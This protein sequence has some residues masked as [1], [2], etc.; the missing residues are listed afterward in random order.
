MSTLTIAEKIQRARNNPLA[1]MS[2]VIDSIDA[3]GTSANHVVDA[4]NPFTQLLEVSALCLQ[5]S[6][7]E[8]RSVTRALYPNLSESKEEIYRHLNDRDKVGI[9]A[10]PS[11]TE[12]ILAISEEEILTRAVT[13]PGTSVRKLTIPPQTR[14]KVN[15][16]EFGIHYPIDIRVLSHGS[17]RAVWNNDAITS[18]IKLDENILETTSRRFNSDSGSVSFFMI[19]VPVEQFS[20]ETFSASISASGFKETYSYTDD[21]YFARVYLSEK[22]VWR[23]IPTTFSNTVYDVNT[24]TAVL[25]DTANGLAVSIPQVYI[26]SGLVGRNVRVDIYTTRGKMELSLADVAP[27][28]FQLEW[29]D[30]DDIEG[31]AYT[32]PLYA[33][34]SIVLRGTGSTIGGRSALTTDSLRERTVNSST[35]GSTAFDLTSEVNDLGYD[36]VRRHDNSTSRVYLLSRHLE[37]TSS[38]NFSTVGVLTDDLTFRFDQLAESGASINRHLNSLTILPDTLYQSTN[39]GLVIITPDELMNPNSYTQDEVI[40]KLNEL[41]PVYSPFHYVLENRNEYFNKRCYLMDQPTVS[42]RNFIDANGS[43]PYDISMRLVQIG[44]MGDG[45]R[46]AIQ[47]K[48]GDSIKALNDSQVNVQLAFIPA[49]SARRV[50]ITG[51]LSSA[52]VDDERVYTFDFGTEFDIDADDV[53]RVS[54]FKASQIDNNDYSLNLSNRFDVIFTVNGVDKVGDESDLDSLMALDMLPSDS[55][56]LS[57]ETVVLT[58][59]SRLAPLEGRTL[60]YYEEA[61]YEE[62]EEDV[63]MLRDRPAYRDDATGYI[64]VSV[65]DNALVYEKI[66]D[67]GDPVLDSEGNPRLLH[68]AGSLKLTDGKPTL[69]EDGYVARKAT[70]VTFNAMFKYA[71]EEAAVAAVQSKTAELLGYVQSDLVEIAK[72]LPPRTEIYFTPKSDMGVIDITEVSGQNYRVNAGLSFQVDLFLT[73]NAYNDIESHSLIKEQVR[74]VIIERIKDDIV[75]SLSIESAIKERLGSEVVTCSVNNITEEGL[76]VAAVSDSDRSFSIAPIMTMLSDGKVTPKDDINVNINS[77]AIDTKY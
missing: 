36:I 55:V 48:S 18:P 71:N 68:E 26:P 58:L 66:A 63:P 76:Q 50:Y 9:Y 49:D 52:Y 72:I 21:F 59:G 47:I 31:A 22:G 42:G 44:Y 39:E 56:V 32:S 54:G 19:H 70:F 6:V 57:H 51:E 11:R 75:S 69:I 40:A 14:F 46:V 53:I 37:T 23:E 45:Y 62:W 25:E 27:N 8:Q 35:G 20:L 1:L 30:F 64:D 7:D 5:A 13:I 12:I 77:V 65:E 29:R 4:S 67:I 60:T 34:T 17:I 74:D 2:D 41:R 38:S 3:D 16:I 15:G 73:A 61:R 33:I 28:A 43:Y 24:V 10:L